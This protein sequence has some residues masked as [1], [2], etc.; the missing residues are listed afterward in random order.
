M[1]VVAIQPLASIDQRICDTVSMAIKKVYGVNVVKIALRPLPQEA[2]VNIKTA[3]YRADKLIYWLKAEKPDSVD[4]IL[5]LTNGDISFTKKDK[6]GKTK[7]PVQRYVDWGIFGLGYQP[8]ASAIV[9]TYRLTNEN[10]EK[11]I[12]RIQKV[13]LHELGHNFGLP[14]CKTES[15]LMQDA[16]ERIATIDNVRMELCAVCREKLRKF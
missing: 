3:R 10:Q 12:E 2:F 11:Y 7:Q 13:A 8:G 15:C 6:S 1:T 4:Y 5:G 9:S 14:H 16:A